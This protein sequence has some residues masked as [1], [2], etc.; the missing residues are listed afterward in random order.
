MED[1]REKD[2]STDEVQRQYKRIKKIRWGGDFLHQSRP[3]LGPTQ[4]S[5]TMGTG[6]ISRVKSGRGVALT[7][8][9]RLST[10][11]T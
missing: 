1:N 2:T 11:F 9:S 4:A 5:Y 8:R 7:T 10:D 3:V 6:F